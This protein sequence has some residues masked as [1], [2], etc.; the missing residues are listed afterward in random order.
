[1]VVTKM[2]LPT[3]TVWT[4]G[5]EDK[6]EITFTLFVICLEICPILDLLLMKYFCINMGN[7]IIF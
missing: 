1:M 7:V 3:E 6:F 5:I 2:P 4:N